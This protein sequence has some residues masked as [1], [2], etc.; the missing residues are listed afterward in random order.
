M[1]GHVAAG[2]HPM[3]DDLKDLRAES[4]KW[5]AGGLAVAAFG[6]LCIGMTVDTG[7]LRALLIPIALGSLAVGAWR[8]LDRSYTGAMATLIVGLLATISI[9][10]M[11]YS[12]PQVLFALPLVVFVAPLLVGYRAMGL[13]ALGAS[14]LV[15]TLA[16]LARLPLS[17]LDVI[18]ALL[19]IGAS[20]GLAW[21]AYRP[22]RTALDWAWASYREERRKTEEVRERQAELAQMSKSLAEACERLEQANV[23]LANARRA[24]EEARRVKDELAT[25]IS[26][27]LR[28]P[29]NLIVG[30]S[31]MIVSEAAA[32]GSEEIPARFRADVEAIYRNACHLS[33]LVDDVLDLGQLD[34]HRLALHKQWS[35]L[36]RIVQEA[37]VTVKS[38]YVKA[39]LDLTIDLPSGLPPVYV[40]PT[41]IR[42][43]LINLLTN[44][45]RYTDEG[46]A[47]VSAHQDGQEIVVSVADTG[48]GIRPEDL[49]HVFE[50]YRPVARPHRR[51]G[52]GLGLTVSKR[53]VEMHAG[54]MWV[55]SEP[56]RGTTFSFS[57]PVIENVAALAAEPNWSRLESLHSGNRGERTLLVLDRDEEAAKI[58]QR[59][60]DGYRIVVAT[61]P[62]KAAQLARSGAISAVVVPHPEVTA[63]AE[64]VRTALGRLPGV[65]LLRCAI[66]TVGR[67]GH[68]LGAAAFLT[69]PIAV[70][71]LRD[72]L[73]R[74]KLRPRRPLIVDDDTDMVVLLG[75]MLHTIAPRCRVQMATSVEQGL[76]LARNGR[77]DLVL[78]DLLMPGMDGHDF[79]RTWHADPA[80]RDVPVIIVSAAT[81]EDNILVTGEFLEIRRHGGLSVADLMRAAH[82]SLGSLLLHTDTTAP[83]SSGAGSSKWV[84]AGEGA[85]RA[86]EG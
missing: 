29:L 25:T 44:A 5:I 78:L 4:L 27:E 77:P 85:R 3:D 41:R 71:T 26:H 28:T 67:I 11:L 50:R 59:Y 49:P 19:L 60:L 73:R 61:T 63:D 13:T 39:G 75:R 74:L 84:L 47:H 20:A 33:D 43:V 48:V 21:L 23:A 34:A 82:A 72:T 52:F 9:T 16:T 14:A 79:L 51:A 64:I 1:I 12:V 7:N 80:L 8:L 32:D 56:G 55:S 38:L 24:A 54:T 69:K 58:F 46:G 31:E 83:L 37:V 42:Q 86:S 70:N 10:A 62:G 18:A 30:F 81:E 68:D 35:A 66:R 17:D 65:P 2:R 53:F 15:L 6:A 76:S 22:M 45:V 57:L 36:P 40:D